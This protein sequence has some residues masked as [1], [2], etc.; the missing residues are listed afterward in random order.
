M[1]IQMCV[2][3]C[4]YT[5]THMHAYTY[6]HMYM[7]IKMHCV[8]TCTRINTYSSVKIFGSLHVCRIDKTVKFQSQDIFK[9]MTRPRKP[10]SWWKKTHMLGL[11]S[12]KWIL[13]IRE[14]CWTLYLYP[15]V[16]ISFVFTALVYLVFWEI[17]KIIQNSRNYICVFDKC[18]LGNN[19][20]ILAI[21]T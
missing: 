13:C 7:H 21:R 16:F 17:N 20:I 9:I 10:S 5:C 15:C 12:F 14:F 8:H 4:I 1:C 18:I 19:L 6:P 11:R 3:S 2:H